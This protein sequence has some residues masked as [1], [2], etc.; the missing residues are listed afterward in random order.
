MSAA[1]E[2]SINKHNDLLATFPFIHVS[3]VKEVHQK[4]KK[5]VIDF[6]LLHLYFSELFKVKVQTSK[7]S[8]FKVS[9]P[10]MSGSVVFWCIDA[11]V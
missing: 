1:V 4:N 8:T 11:T 9:P 2:N 6:P 3:E 10:I 7:S 5:A